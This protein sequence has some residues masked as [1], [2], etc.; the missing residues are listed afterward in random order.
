MASHPRRVPASI[1]NSFLALDRYKFYRGGKESSANGKS[2]GS[3]NVS[4]FACENVTK[5][6][7]VVKP[8]GHSLGWF[9]KPIS[10][11]LFVLVRMVNI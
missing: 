1:A 3:K 7:K 5:R 8:T 2:S 4:L 10:I 6:R 9:A 11:K